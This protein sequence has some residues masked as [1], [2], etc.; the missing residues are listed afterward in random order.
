MQAL[1]CASAD[2]SWVRDKSFNEKA[3]ASDVVLVGR[4]RER[5]V[6]FEGY[7]N[8]RAASI[9]IESVFLERSAPYSLVV[10][11]KI[12][13]VH[14]FGSPEQDDLSCCEL[15]KRYLLFLKRATG[16]EDAYFSTNGPYSAYRLNDPSGG[17]SKEAE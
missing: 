2:A 11:T 15:G 6:R 12:L 7:P 16:R 9:E 3:N 1:T 14:A 10:G 13:Y 5:D 8:T 4:V 17:S